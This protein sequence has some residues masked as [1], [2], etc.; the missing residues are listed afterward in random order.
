MKQLHDLFDLLQTLAE[1]K[2]LGNIIDYTWTTEVV[3]DEMIVDI[4]IIPVKPIEY[5]QLDFS[6]V[7]SNVTLREVLG[8]EG[9]DI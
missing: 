1:A 6:A 7:K 4:G 9:R 2:A 5:I 3:G 8:D